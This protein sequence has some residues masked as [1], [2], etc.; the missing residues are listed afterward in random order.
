MRITRIIPVTLAAF[1][2]TAALAGPAAADAGH[3]QATPAY[4]GTSTIQGPKVAPPP[5]WPTNPQPIVQPAGPPTWPTNPQPIVRPHAVINAQASG[6]DW[7]S[8]GIGAAG[9]V[10]ACAIALAGTV[11]LRRR[12][13]A[14][15][16]S[17]ATP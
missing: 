16:R 10:A 13:G 8:A 11:A 17:L 5:T 7:G 2:C 1:L 9:G 14:R 6:F 15:P 4:A 12:R 3:K